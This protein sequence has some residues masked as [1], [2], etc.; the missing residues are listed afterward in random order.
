MDIYDESG[1]LVFL[2]KIINMSEKINLVI[3]GNDQSILDTQLSLLPNVLAIRCK[4][5]FSKTIDEKLD[6]GQLDSKT[7]LVINLTQNGLK[8]LGFLEVIVVKQVAIIIVGDQSNIG[9]LSR[10]LRLGVKDF[11]D[12]NEYIE[13]FVSVIEAA[14]NH[15][16]NGEVHSD[17]K[18]LN[19]IVNAKGGSGASFIAS[20]IAYLLANEARLKVALLDLDLQFGSIGLNFDRNPHYNFT[21]V[22]RSL[23]ELD[24]YSL[25]AYVTKYDQNLSLVLPSPSE[26]ILPGEV[27]VKQMIKLLDLLKVNYHQIVIDIPRLIDPV[28]NM[29]MQNADYIVLVVQQSLVQFRDAK[30]WVQIMNKDLE[31]SLEKIVLVINR[32]D[33]RNSMRISDLRDMVNHDGIYKV[34]NDYER[35]AKASDFGVPLCLS[36]P[37]A[38]I[39]KDLRLLA[40]GVSGV[41]FNESKKS[42]SNLFGLIS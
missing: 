13:K 10:A 33:A 2:T 32:Y 40:T 27:N 4:V 37:Q 34:A 3:V 15:I 20:N 9:L 16:I 38:K 19:V 24:A 35:V 26:V 17:N 31:I 41:D 23:D 29:V 11:I 5:I 1:R 21:E 36:F 28:S 14:K 22:L 42:L 7:I 6:L 8:E 30:R 25:E 39:A 12:S 18:R